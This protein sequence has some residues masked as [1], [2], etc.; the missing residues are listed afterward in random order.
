MTNQSEVLGYA[1]ETEETTVEMTETAKQKKERLAREEA[2]RLA[3]EEEEEEDEGEFSESGAESE[4]AFSD[5]DGDGKPFR[6]RGQASMTNN[7]G[8][9]DMI[10]SKKALH[11]DDRGNDNYYMKPA[12]R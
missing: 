8:Y 1:P 9:K 5:L 12:K 10:P 2:E 6:G 3:Q 11:F 7:Y 4:V